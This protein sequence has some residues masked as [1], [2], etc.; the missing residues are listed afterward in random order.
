MGIFSKGA[1]V[2][3]ETIIGAVLIVEKPSRPYLG[4]RFQTPFEGMFAQVSLALKEL[5]KWSKAN[6][7]A[8]EAPYFLRYYH[9]DMKATMEV[10]AGLAT[11][12]GL[13]GQGR[14][15]PGALPAGRYASLVYVGNGYTGN[16]TLIEWVR[17]RGDLAFDRWDTEA[18]DNFCSRYERY[19]TDPKQEHRKKKWEIEV[20]IKLKD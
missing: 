7:L 1:R 2:K 6:G 16:K 11:A 15:Q 9:C 8:E 18:G 4:I 10:E 3:A 13:P 17:S 19:L 14:I 5:R 12:C 20:A